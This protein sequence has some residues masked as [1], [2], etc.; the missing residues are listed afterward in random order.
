MRRAALSSILCVLWLTAVGSPAQSEAWWNKAW[1]YRVAVF[2]VN[3]SAG[4]AAHITLPIPGGGPRDGRD[5]RVVDPAGKLI[6]HR[7][8]DAGRDDGVTVVFPVSGVGRMRPRY[9]IYFGN[10]N[11]RAP[12]RQYTGPSGPVLEVRRAE[13]GPPE[14][15][16]AMQALL[17]RSPVVLGRMPVPHVFVGMNPFGAERTCISLV[18]GWIYARRRGEYVYGLNSTD[19]SFFQVNKERVVQ[20]PGEHE[21]N[22]G[23]SEKHS[24]RIRLDRGR[25]P[26]FF[27]HA[28]RRG[29]VSFSLGVK[30]PDRKHLWLAGIEDFLGWVPVDVGRIEA[31]RKEPSAY[32]AWR[33]LHDLGLSGRAVVAMQFSERVS[34]PPREVRRWH[35]DFG[36]GAES[37]EPEPLHLFLARGVYRVSL[38]AEL[39]SGRTI[40]A[41]LRVAVHPRGTPGRAVRKNLEIYARL[42]GTYRPERLGLEANLNAVFVLR[43]L[44]RYA[45]AR[46]FLEAAF[47]TRPPLDS[48]ELSEEA[49]FLAELLRDTDP[50]PRKALAMYRYI[51][52]VAPRKRHRRLAR[53]WTGAI[54]LD[55]LNEVGPAA[56]ILRALIEEDPKARDDAVRLALIKLADVHI[57]GGRIESARRL[58]IRAEGMKRQPT[59]RGEPEAAPGQQLLAYENAMAN[60]DHVSAARALNAWEWIAPLDKL[61][62]TLQFLR[63]D[64]EVARNRPAL[65]LIQLGRLE[66]VNP[67]SPDLPSA[68]MLAARSYERVG[69]V[70]TARS[71]YRRIVE[72]FP[73]TAAAQEARKRLEQRDRGCAS[74][75][76]G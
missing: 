70:A 17:L 68:W 60:E 10:P 45:A 22:W 44:G 52:E 21:P 61:A 58:L 59:F 36:D 35:W 23:S 2:P 53:A 69:D 27:A 5:I 9:W 47:R 19:A 24:G 64:L 55:A 8:L 74:R 39:T 48:V 13:S 1:A 15:W 49:F 51:D 46:P 38:E 72:R 26:F 42:L 62:G 14:S 73:T 37:N 34:V 50:D 66:K 4:P 43:A 32:F 3:P 16:E 25:H 54:R 40:R 29:R 67:S 11:A 75:K 12:A 76:G 56:S 6:E 57:Q 33:H 28:T 65:A 63:A 31:R 20:W 7:I 41:S 30:H 71:Y 18:F